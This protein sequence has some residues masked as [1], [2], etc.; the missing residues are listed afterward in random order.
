MLTIGIKRY[1]LFFKRSQSQRAGAKGQIVIAL[2]TGAAQDSQGVMLGGH[3]IS[4]I[5]FRRKGNPNSQKEMG[6]TR[7]IKP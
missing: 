2:F 3:G 4:L 7:R 5:Q 1:V 6:I